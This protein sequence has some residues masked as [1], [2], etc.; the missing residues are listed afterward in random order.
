MSISY[1]T[2]VSSL[3][4]ILVLSYIFGHFIQRVSEFLYWNLFSYPSGFEQKL[5]KNGV[6]EIEEQYKQ[7][8]AGKMA[9]EGEN[10]GEILDS[11]LVNSD[12][13]LDF[14]TLE[15]KLISIL[16]SDYGM[17]RTI[18]RIQAS[19][20]NEVFQIPF[21]HVTS[22]GVSGRVDR[23]FAI[24]NVFRSLSFLFILLSWISIC[25]IFLGNYENIIP[26][27]YSAFV[28]AIALFVAGFLS[29]KVSQQYRDYMHRA[30]IADFVSDHYR[31]EANS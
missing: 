27:S 9:D 23:F 7:T 16:A 13:E 6:S 30:L 4:T 25:N 11:W 29:N 3:F 5:E 18:Q 26:I 2:G 24:S 28:P 1:S 15:A 8:N 19:K 21:T 20:A 31:F 14:Q 22:Q 10:G 17:N 12:D